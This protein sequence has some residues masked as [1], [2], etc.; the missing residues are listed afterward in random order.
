MNKHNK[1]AEVLGKG[2]VNFAVDVGGKRRQTILYE[3]GYSRES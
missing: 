1:G 2:Q 3:V